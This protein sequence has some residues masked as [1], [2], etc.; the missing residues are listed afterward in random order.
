LRGVSKDGRKLPWFET[1]AKVR[2]SS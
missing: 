1:R 2:F